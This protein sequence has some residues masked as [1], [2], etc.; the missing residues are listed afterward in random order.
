M[1]K[2]VNNTEKTAFLARLINGLG[3]AYMNIRPNAFPLDADYLHERAM[4]ETGLTDFGELHYQEGLDVLLRDFCKNTK[5]NFIGLL[6]FQGV[7]LRQLRNRLRF[8][9]FKK[10]HP[11]IFKKSL[12][13]PLLI[14]GI[15]RSGTTFLHRLMNE[16]EHWRSLKLYEIQHPI[17]PAEGQKDKRK[18][19]SEKELK[20]VALFVPE[21]DS[22]H[23]VRADMPEEC[24]WLMGITF[25]SLEYLLEMQ[26]SDYLEW[27]MQHDRSH[28][29]LEYAQLLQIAQAQEPDKPL[30]LKAPSHRG[31]L[32]Y[33]KAA[34]PN[35]R[36]VITERDQHESAASF[37]SLLYSAL[38][39]N[40]LVLDKHRLGETVLKF[41]SY[42]EKQ[43]K[44]F[45][46]K[47]PD[48]VCQVQ[49]DQIRQD[50]FAVVRKIYQH[51]DIPMTREAEEKMKT[52][53]LIHPQ[54]KYGVHQYSE[55][56][57]G[58]GVE[59]HSSGK[60]AN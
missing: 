40:V 35:I 50:T 9:E 32:D 11:E 19:E 23:L 44:A 10:K 51:Y 8:V 3:S 31:S 4:K 12:L 37:S 17:P 1:T 28:A 60:I 16:D 14:T 20:P 43:Q 30:L 54:H 36:L 33:L 7:L 25:C 42:E 41:F 49:Y 53:A 59:N 29:Y 48:L 38:R 15:P 5:A 34:I 55:A 21:L 22:K 46:T 24:M 56:E 39:N 57:F 18:S 45:L 27:Y 58:I 6:A 26:V 2:L 47:H 52:Y 13:D